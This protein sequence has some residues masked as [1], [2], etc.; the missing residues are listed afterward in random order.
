MDNV[1]TFD[2]Y[3]GYTPETN[4]FGNS[5]TMMGVD[6]STYPLSRR[7]IFGINIVF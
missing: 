4:S 6:Y 1:K 5:N 7:L 3:P 2:N